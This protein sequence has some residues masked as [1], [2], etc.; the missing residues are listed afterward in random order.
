HRADPA[1]SGCHSRMD[2]I[3]FARE[4]YDAIGRWRA[5]DADRSINGSADLPDGTHID[6]PAGLTAL[7]ASKYREDF[8]SAVTDKLLIYALARWLAYYDNPAVRAIMK[9]TSPET[10][11]MTDL[12]AA[13]VE[14]VPF[15]MR[16]TLE[17]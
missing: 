9:R 2:P 17:P 13:I 7:M 4:N 16:R 1:C 14:S 11:R 8:A 5:K 12:I 10:Y 6:G 3:G 15:Q